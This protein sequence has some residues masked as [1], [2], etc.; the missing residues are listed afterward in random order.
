MITGTP[1]Y[2]VCPEVSMNGRIYA[3]KESDSVGNSLH[4]IPKTKFGLNIY[5]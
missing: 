3:I 5:D 2:E 1:P 4:R